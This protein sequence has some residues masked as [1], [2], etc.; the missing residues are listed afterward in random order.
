VIPSAGPYRVASYVP[1]QGVTLTRN[2]NYHGPQPHRPERIALSV[3]ASPEQAVR[4]VEAGSADMIAP[5]VVPT[6]DETTLI[7]KYGADS[8][9][10][11]AG[12][13]QY[14]V[15]PLPALDFFALNTARPLFSSARM[16]RAVNYAV[17][18]EA[19][20]KRGSQFTTLPDKPTD[21]YIP[22]GIP[23]YSS[24]RVFP[25]R[26]DPA[27]AR[28]LIRGHRPGQRVAILYTCNLS[29]CAQHAQI[30]KTDLRSIGIQVRTEAFSTGVLY[31][32][33]AKPN[34]RFDLADLGWAADYLD[35]AEFM[36]FL[37]DSRTLVPQL[38]DVATRHQL[39]RAGQLTGT[40]RYLKYARL[41]VTVARHA[42]PLLA[43][44]NPSSHDLFSARIG[45]QIF[46]P[47][48]MDLG[49]L[50]IR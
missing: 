18:R 7:A 36:N 48:G 17:D 1:G 47:Y 50:C 25:L 33:I 16:R 23:G 19:L 26:G 42:A 35:P 10:A 31:A 38:T 5:S 13:Q 45:C 34:A 3:G 30:L 20:A 41:N 6:R 12:R 8:P 27:R 46:G 15:N 40:A 49:A 21:L 37:I 22:P 43:Y 14:F 11:K 9:A 28:R 2:P 24:K 4:H 29:P 32:K 39:D 44:G